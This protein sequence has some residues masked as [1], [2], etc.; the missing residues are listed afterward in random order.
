MRTNE[1]KC[2]NIACNSSNFENRV[3]NRAT[4]MA[5]GVHAHSLLLALV[6][7]YAS[8]VY[9]APPVTSTAL[10]IRFCRC[11]V[12]SRCCQIYWRKTSCT[13]WC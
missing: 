12:W 8:Y 13:W 10:I 9:P 3:G 5:E 2:S 1:T 6:C 4:S 7:S 11:C